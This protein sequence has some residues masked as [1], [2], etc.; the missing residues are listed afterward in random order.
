MS[1]QNIVEDSAAV[2]E[3]VRDL[4]SRHGL[5]RG[6]QA[7]KLA[8]IL[9]LSLS[10]AYKKLGGVSQWTKDQLQAIATF[11]GVQISELTDVSLSVTDMSDTK[12]GGKRYDAIMEVGGE[13][14]DCVI[15]LGKQLKLIRDTDFVAY[16]HKED[17]IWRVVRPRAAP[18]DHVFLISS[19]KVTLKEPKV[20]SVA[21]LDD[22]RDTTDSFCEQLNDLDLDA[23]PFYDIGTLENALASRKFDAFILDYFIGNTTTVE[24]IR[25]IRA[26]SAKVPI[27][28]L[29]GKSADASPFEVSQMIHMF[30]LNWQSKPSL[31]AVIA[32]EITRDIIQS[33]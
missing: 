25:K 15:Q 20:Y 7:S 12:V 11:Y 24:L 17:G 23:R 19:L 16:K 1:D 10:Q 2:A 29:T 30:S 32:A 31:P 18:F 28:L 14:I 6:Q 13:Q 33:H 3:R 8:E 9:G 4:L 5:P 21:M 22:D 27:V 26:Q